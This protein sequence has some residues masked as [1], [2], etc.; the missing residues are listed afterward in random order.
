MDREEDKPPR[1]HRDQAGAPGRREAG[2]PLSRGHLE[3]RSSGACRASRLSVHVW[4]CLCVHTR[5][6]AT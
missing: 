3:S 5:A 4:M 2:T 6:R 1:A